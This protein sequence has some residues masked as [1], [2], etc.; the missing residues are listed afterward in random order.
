MV[1]PL[2][3]M[4]RPPKN[5]QRSSPKPRVWLWLAVLTPLAAIGTAVALVGLGA[6]FNASGRD[7]ALLASE[8]ALL[9]DI[10]HVARWMDGYVP[11]PGAE[12]TSKTR[13]VDD[14]YTI[15]YVY[16]DPNDQNAPYLAYAITVEAS[17]SDAR[18]TYLSTWGGT[19]VGFYFG[20]GN[21]EVRESS[22]LFTWG[23]ASK[24]ALLTSDG[25]PFGN[26]F[27]ARGGNKVVHLLLTGVYFD[28]AESIEMLLSPYLNS[29]DPT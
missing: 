4:D 9:L 24:F 10:D 17:V 28:E 11:D 7:E 15:D 2:R 22:E 18:T 14:S 26:V 3:T 16:D 25:V 6:V 27:L 12:A 29:L 1:V 13:F 23:D 20:E 5:M 21:V 19:E 8:R